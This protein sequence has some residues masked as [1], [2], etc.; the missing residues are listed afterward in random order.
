MGDGRQRVSS[1]HC[2]PLSYM[3]SIWMFVSRSNGCHWL[4]EA[5]PHC[6]IAWC[7]GGEG[8]RRGEER[9]RRKKM[10]TVNVVLYF[11]KDTTVGSR[12]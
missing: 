8:G 1:A 6:Q 4:R 5:S 9:V 10:K 3:S 7:R 2:D 11:T 12:E